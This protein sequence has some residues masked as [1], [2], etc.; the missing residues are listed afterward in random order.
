MVDETI[1]HDEFVIFDDLNAF[2]Q[3]IVGETGKAVDLESVIRLNTDF[4]D[5][6]DQFL[7]LNIKEYDS[8]EPNNLLLLT[9]R[10][11]FLFSKTPP[12]LQEA[13]T[14]VDVLQ[15]PFGRSTVL[16]FLTLDK[17][18][19]GH[20]AHLER[21]VSRTAKLEDCFD[22]TEYRRLAL[23]FERLSD[24]LEEFHDLLLRLQERRYKQVETQ[25]ISFDYSVLIAESLSLQARCQRRLGVLKDVRQDHEMLATEGLNKKIV[26]LNDV[27]K[28]LTAI[29]VILMLPTLIASHFGMNFVHMPEL[30]LAWAYPAAIIVQIALMGICFAVFRKIRWL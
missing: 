29:T 11:A 19:I 1:W 15:K 28:K 26:D 4:L 22:H 2:S 24:R 18:L 27:V 30:Q 17:V 14:F 25:Y 16:C 21:L 9:E 13:E 12:R 7:L 23:E 8:G 10:K 5:A 20:E 3:A 6:T